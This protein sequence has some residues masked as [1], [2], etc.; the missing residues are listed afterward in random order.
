MTDW[1]GTV[2]VARRSV[3]FTALSRSSLPSALVTTG[4]T[5][6]PRATRPN[7]DRSSATVRASVVP[8]TCTTVAASPLFATAAAL[9]VSSVP[10]SRSPGLM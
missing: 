5:V 10:I 6:A 4:V 2:T 7:F 9:E 3:T 8:L 1:A